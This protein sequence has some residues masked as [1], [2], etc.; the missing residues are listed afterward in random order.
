[1][2][3]LYIVLRADLSPGAKLA[4]A[5][6]ASDEFK[7]AHPELHR[8]WYTGANNVAILEAPDEV[9]LER[10]LDRAGR[11]ALPL[12][13]CREP[14]LDDSLTAVAIGDAAAKLVSSLPLALRPSRCHRCKR[15]LAPEYCSHC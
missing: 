14:D 4:Q 12:A 6:H 7:A 10:L 9:A 15:S 3:K 13:P 11:A 8:A 5:V 2:N 1:M